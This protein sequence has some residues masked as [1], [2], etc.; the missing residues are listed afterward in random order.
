L[1]VAAQIAGI[2]PRSAMLYTLLL[3]CVGLSVL[4]LAIYIPD[5]TLLLPRLLMS[6][7]F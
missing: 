7:Y 1:L 6:R 4:L 2:H 3:S 5:I